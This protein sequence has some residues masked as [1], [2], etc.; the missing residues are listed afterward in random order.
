MNIY[1]VEDERWA[2]AELKELLSCY[3]PE[4]RVFAF[5]N[6][7]DAWAAVA[8]HR[9]HLVVTDINMPGMDGLELIEQL[10]RLDAAVK[11][12]I[13][14]VHDQFE[15]ARQGM[16]FG[17][18]DYLLK[19]VK[20]EALFQAVSKAIRQIESERKQREAFLNSS[21]AQMLLAADEGLEEASAFREVNDRMWGMVLLYL[22]RGQQS[23]GWNERSGCLDE[24]KL[25]LADAVCAG[26]SVH[27]V[28][29]D[30]RQKVILIPLASE[31]QAGGL[32]N[33]LS[34][35]YHHKLKQ[36]PITAHMG[37]AVKRERESLSAAFSRLKQQL[38]EKATFGQTSYLSPAS[39]QQDAE[40][41]D[42]WDKVRVMEL[43]YKKGDMAKGQIVLQHILAELDRKRISKRQLRLFV[44][45]LLFSLKYNLLVSKTGMV[46]LNDLQEDLRM[47]DGCTGYEELFEWL[48][49]LML[50][51]YCEQEPK[52]LNPKGLIPVLLQHIHKH[53]QD[54]I[55]LQ[56]F[57][58]DHHV[59]LGYLSRMFKSQ[60]G[61]TFSD[62][63]AG[64]RIRKAKE[65]LSEGVDRLQ[66]VSLLVGYEDTKHFSALFKKI[67][68]E[69]PIMYARKHSLPK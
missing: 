27:N 7:D 20:K 46:R 3:E 13:L 14:S 33:V 9:P 19:P 55:S 50:A 43:H 54:N 37:F 36:L 26:A 21:L 69:T 60:T 24:L 11:C 64:Y 45:D 48:K 2:L 1:V 44:Q 40:L 67:V 66:E 22:E 32:L 4:H 35:Y 41:G 25:Q 5:E 57:A 42:I 31:A 30:Y 65:L 34:G 12:I 10:Y 6:G 58:A 18:A 29:V 49:E 61:T 16:Q 62:Y 23:K 56:Q 39:T 15:Y 47:L 53:Y 51:F 38:M 59:S 68:G 28:D 52:E 8:E 63:I 17:V